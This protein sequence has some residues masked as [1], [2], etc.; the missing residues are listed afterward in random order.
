MTEKHKT[1]KFSTR[2]FLA[3]GCVGTV[4]LWL[5]YS[6]QYAPKMVR[7]LAADAGRAILLPKHT[8]QPAKWDPNGITAAW[9]GHS[10]VLLNFFGLTIL[11]DP[12]LGKRIGADTCV[13]AGAPNPWVEPALTLAE[14]PP[15]DLVLLSHA[16]MD[17]LDP[18][19]LR[20]LPGAPRI[21]T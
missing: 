7:E 1:T 11:T 13:G 19:T 2:Q 20:R 14:L 17:H 18:A 3:L 12:V 15:I 16:H 8:P 21:V 4:G 5:A 6:D 10:T 9:L